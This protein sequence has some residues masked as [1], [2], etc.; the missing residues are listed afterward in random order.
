METKR[1]YYVDW[2]RVLVILSL[3]PFHAA[4]TYLRFGLVYIKAPVSGPAAL[5]AR[6]YLSVPRDRLPH[7]PYEGYRGGFLNFIPQFF[8]HRLFYYPG[9]GHLWFLLY[10][11]VFSMICVPLFRRWQRDESRIGRIGAFFSKGHRLLLPVGAVILLELF[12]RPFPR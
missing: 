7:G 9:Y 10:L 3:I 4:L 11:F 6:V 8:Y 2:L 12:L 1:L 5:P